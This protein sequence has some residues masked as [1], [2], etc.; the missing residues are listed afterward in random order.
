MS[1]D[2]LTSK[3]V[4]WSSLFLIPSENASPHLSAFLAAKS[5]CSQD[6]LPLFLHNA[7]RRELTRSHRGWYRQADDI[8]Q[9]GKCT[10][11]VTIQTIDIYSTYYIILIMLRYT[12]NL[13]YLL[14]SIGLPYLEH[15]SHR[16]VAGPVCVFLLCSCGT[17]RRSLGETPAP[18][19]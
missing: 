15:D 19:E 18:A 13:G 6:F 2:R 16:A 4:G 14:K 1:K 17:A 10:D 7:S 8:L 11:F 12:L 3:F 9:E 5:N